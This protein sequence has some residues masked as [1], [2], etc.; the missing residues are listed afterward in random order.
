MAEKDGVMS[1]HPVEAIDV[2]AGSEAV[3]KPGGLHV[4]LIGLT[5]DLK[6]GEKVVV[7]LTF[8]KAGERVVEAEVR[9]R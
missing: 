3:L 6:V 7:K 4:M 8:E 2:P 5:R 1:M 9:E